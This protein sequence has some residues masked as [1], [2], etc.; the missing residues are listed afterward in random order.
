M[1]KNLPAMQE[2][3]VL[4]LGQEDPLEKEMVKPTPVALPSKF[5]GQRSWQ[6]TVGSQRVG[7]DW[8]IFTKRGEGY[9]TLF[10]QHSCTRCRRLHHTPASFPHLSPLTCHKSPYLQLYRSSYS[11]LKWCAKEWFWALPQVLPFVWDAPSSFFIY[12]STYSKTQLKGHPLQVAFPHLVPA[13]FTCFSCTAKHIPLQSTYPAG[14]SLLIHLTVSPTKLLE[15]R[16]HVLSHF[17]LLKNRK[18]LTH[19]GRKLGQ[20]G[21]NQRVV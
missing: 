3:R 16:R 14:S 6:A 12:L 20:M 21:R 17:V 11:S 9:K 13:W 5:H 2:T 8:V 4:S 18:C 19:Q 10:W 7:H 1:I 15:G